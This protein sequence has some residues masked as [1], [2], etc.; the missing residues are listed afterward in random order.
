MALIE[1]IGT[2]DDDIFDFSNRDDARFEI[3][4]LGGDDE[5]TGGQLNDI[6]SGGKGN[7]V[8]NGE[9][10]NDKMLGGA[11]NDVLFGGDGKDNLNGG[12][13][14]DFLNGNDGDASLTGGGGTDNF[15]VD[16]GA[17]RVFITD[18]TDNVDTLLLDGDFFPGKSINQ[19]LTRFGSSSGG[20]SA[21]D[22]SGTGADSPRIILLGVDNI[23]DLKDDITII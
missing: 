5:I 14:V 11:G 16:E 10:G 3:S 8:M 17:G 22:L 7:D 12:G 2:V 21:I 18:F 6:L 23:F 9:G 13:G 4:G 15:Q 19:I 20:D 1:K